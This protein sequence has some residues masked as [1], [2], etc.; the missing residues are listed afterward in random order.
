MNTEQHFC[1]N[2]GL[3]SKGDDHAIREAQQ[4]ACR[5]AFPSPQAFLQFE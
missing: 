4:K 1:K 3:E 5:E 2:T